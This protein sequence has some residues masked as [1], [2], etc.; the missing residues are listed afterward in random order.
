VRGRQ[1][2]PLFGYNGHGV[3]SSTGSSEHRGRAAWIRAIVYAAACWTVATITGTT[4]RV[5]GEPLA[6]EEQLGNWRWW[7]FLAAAVATILI[8]YGVVW[9]SNT[10]IFEIGGNSIRISPV[11]GSST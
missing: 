11:W 1:R 10:L 9:S 3:L 2:A 4:A 7:A 8:A 5:F 6:T